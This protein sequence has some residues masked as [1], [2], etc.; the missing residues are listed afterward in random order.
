MNTSDIG[1]ILGSMIAEMRNMT[2]L[3]VSLVGIIKEQKQLI[4]EQKEMLKEI[5]SE[6]KEHMLIT[7]AI[8]NRQ[9][10]HDVSLR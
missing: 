4:Q 10:A 6:Q 3:N 7:H 2:Q 5:T 9:I 1:V 8:N